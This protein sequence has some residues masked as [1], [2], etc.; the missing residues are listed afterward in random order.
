MPQKNVLITGCSS[1]FGLETAISLAKLDFNVFASMRD[2]S[3][4][5]ELDKACKRHG[6]NVNIKALDVTNET[7][8]DQLIAEIKEQEGRLD[9]LIN[10]AGYVQIGFFEE[11]EEQE[12]YKQLETNFFGVQR[13]TRKCLSLLK[14]SENGRIINISSNAGLNAYP[15]LGAYNASKWA[16]EA[17]SES[18]RFELQASSQVDVFLVEPGAFP[19]KCLGE[20][21]QFAE[22]EN[23][24]GVYQG[25]NQKMR[26]AIFSLAH[27]AGNKVEDVVEVIT[28]LAT[29]KTSSF[30]NLVG[31]GVAFRFFLR[32]FLPWSI[33]EAIVTKRMGVSQVV[34][35]S[36]GSKS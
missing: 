26:K 18:L 14:A 20:N 31:K 29:G 30:R 21:T 25:M 27:R 9:V 23:S 6:V 13:V 5:G 3:K 34:S 7:S 1:G 12:I 36:S 24:L 19:T 11:L 32:K 35:K 22:K 4:R 8:I 15:G 2:L 16:L 28:S 17:F 33:Y 10:N